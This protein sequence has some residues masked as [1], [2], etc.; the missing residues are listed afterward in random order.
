MKNNQIKHLY[1][2]DPLEMLHIKSD[3]SFMIIREAHKRGH[4]IYSC[5][6]LDLMLK[7][8]KS[9]ISV[10]AKVKLI[11]PTDEAPGY[12]IKQEDEICLNSFASVHMR[13]D[14]PVDLNFYHACLLLRM[15]E[16]NTFIVN[17]PSSIIKYNEKIVAHLFP[18]YNAPTIISCSVNEIRDFLDCYEGI[19]VVKPLN[20]CSGRGVF[21]T[22]TDSELFEAE[23][24]KVTSNEQVHVVVQKF[25]PEVIEGETRIFLLNGKLLG[26][27]KKLPKKGEFRANLSSGGTIHPITLKKVDYE[28]CE[29]IGPF[30]KQEGIILAAID[31]ING[32]LSEINLTSPGLLVE[33]KIITKQDYEVETQDVLDE[34]SREFYRN[35]VD[36]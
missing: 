9:L 5:T 23:I 19:G 3:T 11:E 35:L 26:A 30:L 24:N 12:I 36:L 2:M 8:D 22:S 32:C 13:K 18:Q 20:S 15:A 14:P 27:F 7:S 16:H 6:P 25:L 1:I 34:L 17:K 21:K 29:A 10:Y 31:I 4:L 28:I 33:N